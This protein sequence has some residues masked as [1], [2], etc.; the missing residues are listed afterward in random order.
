M[1]LL[2]EK[3]QKEGEVL[4][5]DILQD[6]A[7]QGASALA[8]RRGELYLAPVVGEVVSELPLERRD[9]GGLNH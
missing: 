3:I 2:E 7:T 8:R 5:D 4:G 6:V 1:K 9:V